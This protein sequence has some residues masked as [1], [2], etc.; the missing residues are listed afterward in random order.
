MNLCFR[1]ID[2]ALICLGG[3]AQAKEVVERICHLLCRRLRSSLLSRIR[4]VR[5]SIQN[6]HKNF[7]CIFLT[8]DSSNFI[9]GWILCMALRKN[10]VKISLSCI[11]LFLFISSVVQASRERQKFKLCLNRFNRSRSLNLLA[12]CSRHVFHPSGNFT[13]RLDFCQQK[14][15]K[16]RL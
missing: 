4:E 8:R 16:N 2:I 14:I 13:F 9:E 6:L 15:T 1:C 5:W 3:A 7:A 11:R 12:C 10:L